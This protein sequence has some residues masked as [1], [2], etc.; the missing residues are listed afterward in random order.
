MR[1]VPWK[2]GASALRKA[3]QMNAALAA[4]VTAQIYAGTSTLL[5]LNSRRTLA[6]TSRISS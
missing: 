5:T 3:R 2:S 6:T 4:E 1:V